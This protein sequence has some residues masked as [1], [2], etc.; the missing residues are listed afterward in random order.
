MDITKN[1]T[2][3]VIVAH[4]IEI[5][6]QKDDKSSAVVDAESRGTLHSSSSA[7]S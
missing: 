7:S 2:P 4:P 6:L 3:L 5:I 1:L